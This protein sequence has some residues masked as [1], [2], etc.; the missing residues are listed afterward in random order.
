MMF[1]KWVL[2]YNPVLIIFG[3]ICI[4]IKWWHVYL[5]PP[6]A[7]PDNPPEINGTN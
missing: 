6:V 7:H 2:R 1:H 5:Y 4:G 3:A